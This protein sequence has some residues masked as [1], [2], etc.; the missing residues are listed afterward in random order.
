MLAG[1]IVDVPA[2]VEAEALAKLEDPE[3]AKYFSDPKERKLIAKRIANE[4]NKKFLAGGTSNTALIL[5]TQYAANEIIRTVMERVMQKEGARDPARRTLW[6]NK[7]LVPINA[8]IKAAKAYS[9]ATKCLEVFQA[10]IAGN[11][12]QAIG[13]EL[14]RQELGPDLAKD[15]P[16]RYVQCLQPEKPG[17]NKRMMGCVLTHVRSSIAVY[18]KDKVLAIAKSEVPEA[19]AKI[20]Q[21]TGPAFEKCLSTARSKSDFSDCA[22]YFAIAAGA[23]IA[24]EA[25]RRNPQVIKQI[26]GKNLE[27]LATRTKSNFATCMENN[28]ATG[29]RN[30]AGTLDTSNCANLV[31][32]DAAKVVA[33]ELFKDN[34]A[35]NVDGSGEEKNQLGA[36][37]Y[38]L[39]DTCWN[40]SAGESVNNACLR[41]TVQQLVS[42]IADPQLSKEL[43]AALIAKEPKFKDT[44]LTQLR[45][46]MESRLPTNMMEANDTNERVAG[47]TGR[48]T[49]DA[50]LKVAEF[51]FR[52]ILFG[53]S[54][55]KVIDDLVAKIIKGDFARCL[56]AAPVKSVLDTCSITLRLDAGKAAAEALIP[57]EFDRFVEN[58][59]GPGAYNL[60]A[61]ERKELLDSILKTHRKCLAVSPA[62]KDSRLADTLVD[63]CFKGTIKALSGRLGRMEFIRS[64]GSYA[65]EEREKWTQAADEMVADFG[66][67][68]SEKDS[69]QF[70]L[71]DYLGQVDTCRIRLTTVYTQRVAQAQ[72][73][74]ALRTNLPSSTPAE[75]SKQDGLEKNLMGPFVTCVSEIPAEDTSGM[76]RCVNTLQREATQ[77]IAIE[78]GRERAK[79][80]LNTDKLPKELDAIEE[81]FRE[82]MGQVGKISDACAKNY[83][84]SLA[85]FLAGV[86]MRQSLADVLGKKRYLAILPTA[87]SAEKEFVKCVDTEYLAPLDGKFLANID[88]CSKKLEEELV[89][90]MQG[91][92]VSEMQGEKKGPEAQLNHDLAVA[93]PCLGD[94]MPPTPIESAIVTLDPASFLED[95]A[96]MIGEFINYD[97]DQAGADYEVVIK[98][99][100][101]DLESAG[102]VAAREKLLKLLIDRGM[103]DRLLKSMVR[104][105]IA[106]SLTALPAED[107][108]PPDLEKKLMDKATV[109]KAIT[110]QILA[111][112]RPIITEKMLKP[113]LLEGKGMSDPKVTAA[114]TMLE[115]RVMNSLIESPEF[116]DLIVQ[117][118]I[119]QSI[120]AKSGN[121]LVRFAGRVFAGYKTYTWN[122]VREKPAGKSAE[123]YLRDQIIRPRLA[124]EQ[125]PDFSERMKKVSD[126]V[127][128]ALKKP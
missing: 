69:S 55:P 120:D 121:M 35:A 81:K 95:F 80:I 32:Y 106:E 88:R 23:E 94:L 98:Q 57:N 61:E 114:M 6:V 65:P 74:E 41:K 16:A 44:L 31:R 116:G 79:K 82:C 1:A 99:L 125:I 28:R 34:I 64:V 73:K 104:T 54:N 60:Q 22:D 105:R 67:C 117:G 75:I 8:C 59:G 21:S 56:G 19:A 37:I 51:Q 119:Q 27:A 83:A 7:V 109:E 39:L 108:M 12:G 87:E 63:T 97:V 72:L 101:K 36:K 128:E 5:S 15:F 47:C 24:A 115:G 33:Y 18:G 113:M 86:K 40:S 29:K 14:I 9:E 20:V 126:M 96:K 42:T 50:G 112:L 2:K 78:A 3:M 85:K 76:D 68:L 13:Y 66:A 110:P 111:E 93:I 124:G 92:F 62:P 26:S 102:P 46:C 49:R 4:V 38:K 48:L 25:V 103:I 53:R 58:H 122:E 45:S 43:P 107:R 11:L 91:E 30:A 77:L 118:K 123:A 89:G 52:D 100:V 17:S 10:D 71:R 84:R 127:Q 90:L 70:S